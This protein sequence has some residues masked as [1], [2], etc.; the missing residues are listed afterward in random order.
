M[1]DGVYQNNNVLGTNG[2]MQIARHVHMYSTY[3]FSNIG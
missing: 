1:H 3:N 2:Q